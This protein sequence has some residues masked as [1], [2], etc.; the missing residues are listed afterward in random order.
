[1]KVPT[2]KPVTPTTT[3]NTD[4]EIQRAFFQRGSATLENNI[5]CSIGGIMMANML[6][7]NAPMREM[8]RWSSGMATANAAVIES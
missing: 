4:L 5:I 1:M 2:T 7:A 3:I 6:L 8:K